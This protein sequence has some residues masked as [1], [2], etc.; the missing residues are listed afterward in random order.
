MSLELIRLLRIN[1]LEVKMDDKTKQ[2]LL[3]LVDELAD[4]RATV[5]PLAAVAFRGSNQSDVQVAKIQAMKKN[6]KHYRELKDE[7]GSL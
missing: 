2:F 3:K 5:G 7:I 4:L 6:Y 1:N